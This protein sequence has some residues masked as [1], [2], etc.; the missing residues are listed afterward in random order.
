VSYNPSNIHIGGVTASSSLLETYNVCEQLFYLSYLAPHP[1][2]PLSTGLT[3]YLSSPALLFGSLWHS[4]MEAYRTTGWR[5]GADTGEYDAAT[6]IAYLEGEAAGMAAQFESEMLLEETRDAVIALFRKWVSQRDITSDWRVAP[7]PGTDK[8]ML[9]HELTISVP[10][11][12]LYTVKIDAGIITPEGWFEILEYKTTSARYL[13]TAQNEARMSIQGRG[14]A[15]ALYSHF[16]DL[17]VNGVRF[18]YAVKDRGAKSDLP[19]FPYIH[20]D[21]DNP[22]LVSFQHNLERWMYAITSKIDSYNR[23]LAANVDPL[24]AGT[25]IFTMGGMAAKICHRYNRPCQFWE[26]CESGGL[27]THLPIDR[28]APRLV[29]GKPFERPT[30]TAPPFMDE[31][32]V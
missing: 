10:G 13:T 1:D 8:P 18:E 28:M 21:Y 2:H 14:E 19:T 20:I 11:G 25:T 7:I 26:Y 16:P 3:T 4:A 6:T 30:E 32:Q 17:S 23:L 31:S 22:Q 24:T 27:P 9:E 29:N 12:F 5:D 15:L